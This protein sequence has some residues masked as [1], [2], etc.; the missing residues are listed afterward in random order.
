MVLLANV[1]WFLF[2]VFLIW[3]MWKNPHPFTRE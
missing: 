1:P 3:K 2:P